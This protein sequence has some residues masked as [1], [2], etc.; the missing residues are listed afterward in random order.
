M[1]I[2][3]RVV[4][5]SHGHETPLLGERPE[6]LV[7]RLALEKARTVSKK[8]PNRWVL[9]ADTVV[10]Y[11]G[12]IFGKPKSRAEARGMLKSLRGRSHR[13]LTGLALVMEEKGIRETRLE[14][15][16]VVFKDFSL[17]ALEK[18]IASKEPYDKAGGYDIRGTA[19]DWVD[20]WEGNYFNVVG[21]PLEWLARR[22]VGENLIEREAC[23]L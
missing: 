21:L 15:T 12:R 18:Y 9:G 11:K 6:V 3:F 2:P 16:K 20:H 17:K 23:S 8:F 22:L 14:T 5:P 4:K 19:R 7:R 1:G 13:V 10:V